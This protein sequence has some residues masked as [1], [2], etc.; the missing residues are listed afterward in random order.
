MLHPQTDSTTPAPVDLLDQVIR[1]ARARG[2][3]AAEAVFAD[4]RSLSVGVR[5]GAVE[6]VESDE[7]ADLGLRVFVGQKQAVVS[8]SEF[9]QKTLE[10]LVDRCIAMA[11][12]A[13]DD[14]Y[15]GLADRDRLFNGPVTD[16]DIYDPTELNA[17]TLKARALTCEAAGVGVDARLQTDSASA[18]RAL[19]HWTMLTSD[20]FQGDHRTSLF[21]QSARLIATDAD[22][23]MEREGEGRSTRFYSDLPTPEST[24]QM[25]AD[26]ALKAMGARKIDSQTAPVLFEPRT[27]K[28]ILGLLLGAISG[29]AVARGSSYL[30][31]RLGQ[32]I[33]ADGVHVIDNPFRKR[34]L[35]SCYYDDEGV[36]V[37]ERHLIEDGVLTTW[38]LNSSAGRQ[39]GMASTGHASRSLAHPAGVSAHNVILSPGARSPDDM[40]R[41]A[42]KGVIVTSMFGPSVNSDTGD[43]SAG[44][45]GFWFENGEIAYP[46]NEITVAGNL[47]D[48]FA[49]L[50]PASDLDIK[51]TTDAPSILIN[52]L[53]IGGK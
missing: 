48:I 16:L 10:R 47:I 3:D 2:A 28:S 9:S 45:S 51:G 21:F 14:P 32:K 11:S 52:A 33:F 38:L 43:W 30:K 23:N 13:P 39:L 42:G 20:G 50:E 12:L 34:G 31:D 15:T 22:G 19:T 53:N 26:R 8:V 29:T 24:G 6:V 7:T 1:A 27:A 25:A 44:A 36:A 46:V 18:G 40:I 5:K 49:R 17:E 41:A 37:S 4:S 35:G